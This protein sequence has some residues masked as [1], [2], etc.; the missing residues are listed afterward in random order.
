M[1]ENG[2]LGSSL[3][4]QHRE[5]IQA[6]QKM[7]KLE[8]EVELGMWGLETGGTL[9]QLRHRLTVALSEAMRD[10]LSPT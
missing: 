8:L 5:Q 2:V 6:V 7:P 9:K 1:R 4:E 3:A 10:T